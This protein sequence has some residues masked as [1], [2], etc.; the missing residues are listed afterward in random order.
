[1]FENVFLF[2]FIF[3]FITYIEFKCK[4]KINH[5]GKNCEVILLFSYKNVFK[6][7]LSNCSVLPKYKKI[8]I[9]TSYNDLIPQ[10]LSYKHFLAKNQYL[11]KYEYKN[12]MCYTIL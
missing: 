12:K 3:I 11:S 5:R 7:Q 4:I 10:A 9:G 6:N 1:M 8:I 2:Y